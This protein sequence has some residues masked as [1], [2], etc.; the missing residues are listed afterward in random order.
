M[1]G[2]EKLHISISRFRGEYSILIVLAFF[3][4]AG[5][6]IH[7]G[8][9]GWKGGIAWLGIL[10]PVFVVLYFKR[11]GEYFVEVTRDGIGWRKD[12]I[13]RYVYIPW[14]YMQRVDYLVFEINF[15]LKETGQVVCFPTS[16]LEDNQTETLKQFIS[17]VVKDKMDKGE[18]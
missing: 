4:F 1:S 12:I 18:L 9:F 16:G 8:F 17:D 2:S 7:Y 10:L 11:R 3:I 5:W 15:K 6:A 14:Q 13:S